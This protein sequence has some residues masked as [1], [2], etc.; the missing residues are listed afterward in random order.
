MVKILVSVSIKM[1]L[2]MNERSEFEFTCAG[3]MLFPECEPQSF[4]LSVEQQCI[5]IVKQVAYERMR[6]RSTSSG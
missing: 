1:F 5:A 3:F 2:R 4:A 6:A